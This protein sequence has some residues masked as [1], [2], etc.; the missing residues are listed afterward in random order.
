M[1]PVFL[2]G[3]H[4]SGFILLLSTML[5][6]WGWPDLDDDPGQRREL[7]LSKFFRG[8]LSAQGTVK[9]YTGLVIRTFLT[10]IDAS[11]V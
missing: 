5:V 2:K 3:L 4:R 9:D 8:E 7:L 10:G 6:G 11:R 1:F